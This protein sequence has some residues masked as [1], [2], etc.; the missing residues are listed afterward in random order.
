MFEMPAMKKKTLIYIY[1]L[2]RSGSTLVGQVLGASDNSTCV[3]EFASAT[4]QDSF[5]QKLSEE[6]NTLSMPCGCGKRTMDCSKNLL[7]QYLDTYSLFQV[8]RWF[9]NFG[10]FLPKEE[11]IKNYLQ[12]LKTT[13]E[14]VETNVIVDTSKNP[15]LYYTLRNSDTFQ[16]WN[17][18]GVLVYRSI[19]QVWKSWRSDKSYLKKKTRYRLARHLIGQSFWC[20]FTFLLCGKSDIFINFNRFRKRPEEYVA[21]LND[22]F[23]LNI[24][25][26]DRKI[27]V[28]TISHEVGG[29]PSKL[30]IKGEIVVK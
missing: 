15:R 1:G 16:D 22:R 14:N 17:I 21:M 29:N 18:T 8:R 11:E 12:S 25:I 24:S 3:G 23:H 19:G 7:K 5:G 27:P 2:G 13:Y 28:K 10:T 30:Q 4:T 6:E 20:V 26:A 9:S